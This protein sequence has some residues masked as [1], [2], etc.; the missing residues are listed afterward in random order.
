VNAAASGLC[1]LHYMV[2]V[3]FLSNIVGLALH[4]GSLC[5]M[6]KTYSLITLPAIQTF[7]E[8]RT[9][10]IMTFVYFVGAISV[11]SKKILI[12]RG[13]LPVTLFPRSVTPLPLG[14]SL[15][16]ANIP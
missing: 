6:T 8:T 1:H 16:L 9:N 3:S 10:S 5:C 13:L 12:A 14:H 4:N 2:V 11:S 7:H 15:P